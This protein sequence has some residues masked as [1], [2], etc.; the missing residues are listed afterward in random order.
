MASNRSPTNRA[1]E[2][3]RTNDLKLIYGIGPAVEKRLNGVGIFT[4]TQLAALSPA[5]IA[6]AVAGL[7]GLSAER[8][9]KQDW[10]GQAR[11]LG[12]ESTTR[13]VHEEFEAPAD[14]EQVAKFT[15]PVE[16]QAHAPLEHA[17]AAMPWDEPQNTATELT[18]NEVQEEFEA[19]ADSERVDILQA[20]YEQTPPIDLT[21]AVTPLE[22][23]QKGT[24]TMASKEQFHPAT[25]TVDLLL[26]ENNYVHSA[27]V[28]HVESQRE[29]SW[30]G[31]PNTEL[32]DFLSESVELNIPSDEPSLPIAEEPEQAP[33]LIT[34]SQPP[35]SVAAKPAL[36]GTLYL[37]DMKI[38]TAGSSEPRRLLPHDQPI[39][40]RLTLDLSE[41]TVP[42]NAPLD[43]KVSIYRK[44]RSDPSG[45]IV[46]ETE[47]TIK[48]ADNVTIDV[49]GNLLAVGSYRLAATVILALPGTKP[50]P[51]PDCIAVIDGGRVRVY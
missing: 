21:H 15:A 40:V 34:D 29:H 46:G 33:A 31:W 5:D 2:P 27:H 51:K 18:S 50:T 13:E 38:L 17:H 9:V 14:T 41:I 8:I 16:V 19:P 32:V 10:I 48:A 25:F 42:G 20:P 47:G 28:I 22:E 24:E 12:A 35:T 30:T 23:P 1:A 39:D 7:A 43:Y 36:V 45:Q 4:F 49:E 26:D 11:R 44:S 6:A 37:R 3:A